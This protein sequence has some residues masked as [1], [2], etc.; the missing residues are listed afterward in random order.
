MRRSTDRTT[1]RA[2]ISDNAEVP[3]ERDLLIRRS[4]ASW[5]QDRRTRPGPR[6]MTRAWSRLPPVSPSASRPCARPID[7]RSSPNIAT[8][9][10]EIRRGSALRPDRGE[11]LRP[12]RRGEPGKVRSESDGRDRESGY[13]PDRSRLLSDS[14]PVQLLRG[15][16]VRRE[17]AGGL[18]AERRHPFGGRGPGPDR[19]GDQHRRGPGARL[20]LPFERGP[21][22]SG[23]RE[24]KGDVRSLVDP[25]RALERQRLGEP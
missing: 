16:A 18:H 12:F 21:G 14:P 17:Y 6:T 20:E 10:G 3:D 5:P 13:V 8:F 11:P 9:R 22:R 19:H 25:E 15:H 1:P 24:E 2:D 7:P 4:R 23:P